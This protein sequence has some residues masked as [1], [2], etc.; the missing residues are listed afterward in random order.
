MQHRVS[1][2]VYYED[3]DCLGIVYY[4]NYFKYMERGRSE[5][6]EASGTKLADW[7]DQGILIVV[8]SATAKYRKPAR[9]GDTLDVISTLSVDSRYRATFHH[10]IECDGTLL[11]SGEVQVVCV[12]TDQQ[13]RELPEDLRAVATAPAVLSR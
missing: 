9:L 5:F 2:K 7:N 6:L 8:V 4:A 11:V 3:T 10:R 1:Y 13:L 12:D